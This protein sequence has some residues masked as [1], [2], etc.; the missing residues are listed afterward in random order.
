MKSTLQIKADWMDQMYLGSHF[1]VIKGPSKTMN[2]GGL[3][4]DF[5]IAGW[6]NHPL[7]QTAHC[8]ITLAILL[9]CSKR[10]P[11]VL[12][13]NYQVTTTHTVCEPWSM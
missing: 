10:K 4:A 7:L 1:Q 2:G 8:G 12:I 11:T 13:S 9:V 3:M 5:N 6:E